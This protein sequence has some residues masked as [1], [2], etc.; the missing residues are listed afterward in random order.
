[1][2]VCVCVCGGG[3]GGHRPPSPPG[4]ATFDSHQHAL[5]WVNLYCLTL[6]SSTC[7]ALHCLHQLVLPCISFVNLYCLTLSSSTCTALHCLHQFELPCIAFINLYC[8]ALPSSTCTALH[9]LHQFVLPCIAFI[10]LYWLSLTCIN[11]IKII[12]A[13]NRLVLPCSGLDRPTKSNCM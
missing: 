12:L 1:M 4:F 7:S 3:E 9:C 5:I 13:C 10:N 8:L 2:Q 6:P 11:I